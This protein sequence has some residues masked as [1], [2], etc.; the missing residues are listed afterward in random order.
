MIKHIKISFYYIISITVIFYIAGCAS[1][2][3]NSFDILEEAKTFILDITKGD[4]S[5]VEGNEETVK[6]NDVYEKDENNKEIAKKDDELSEQTIVTNK[7]KRKS[8]I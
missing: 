4:Q 6:S 3:N 8:R 1:N 5:P 7:K 2:G